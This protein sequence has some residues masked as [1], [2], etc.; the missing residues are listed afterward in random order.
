MEKASSHWAEDC[1][2]FEK[3]E[4]R[5]LQLTSNHCPNESRTLKRYCYVTLEFY[6]LFTA[7][8]NAKYLSAFIGRLSGSWTV[9]ATDHHHVGS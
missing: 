9:S 7:D 2:E 1:N 5:L 3:I 4:H 6:N 8:M